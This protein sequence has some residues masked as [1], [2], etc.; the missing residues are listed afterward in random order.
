[1]RL[2][3][4]FRMDKCPVDHKSNSNAWQSLAP[5]V[6]G[7][8]IEKTKKN[9][10]TERETSSIPRADGT[11]WVYP[12]EAQF[13]TA[14]ARKQHNPQ[15]Q[16]MKSIVPIHNIVN[17]RAWQQVREWEVGRGGEKCG[18]IKLL[19][20]QGK[21]SQLSLRARWN[22]LLGYVGDSLSMRVYKTFRSDTRLPS[23]DTTG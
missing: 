22:T 4:T 3:K 1:M 17:E 6:N 23:I 13:F 5:L 8:S 14:M 9:L 7:S 16:D 11:H 20:F 15:Q 18:G 21:P 19:S 2:C 10:S 12:S